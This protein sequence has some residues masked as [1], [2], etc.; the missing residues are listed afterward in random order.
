[1]LTIPAR[2]GRNQRIILFMMLTISHA[3]RRTFE[4][5]LLRTQ[6]KAQLCN[7]KMNTN[8]REEILSPYIN[9]IWMGKPV[10]WFSEMPLS[11]LQRLI[12]L[13]LVE[14]NSWNSCPGVEQLFLPFLKRNPRFNAHGYVQVSGVNGN[15]PCITIEG[16]EYRGLISTNELA[17]FASTFWETADELS[18][19]SHL[20]RCWYD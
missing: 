18:F 3:Q 8:L 12:A 11:V 4:T 7:T 19:G 14:M 10:Q 15:D 5:S 6:G 9:E 2:D 20:A 17:D 1:M 16:L 13:G